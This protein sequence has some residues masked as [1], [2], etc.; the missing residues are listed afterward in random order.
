MCVQG[1]IPPEGVGLVGGSPSEGAHEA[2]AW[3][4]VGIFALGSL[5][6]C[7]GDL[8]NKHIAP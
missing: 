2:L 6:E 3:R 7:E 4:P 1:L 8:R 5:R